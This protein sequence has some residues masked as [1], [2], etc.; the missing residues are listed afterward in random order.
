[1]SHYKENNESV[2]NYKP[3]RRVEQSRVPFFTDIPQ[4]HEHRSNP[5]G[6]LVGILD[7]TPFRVRQCLPIPPCFY[8]RVRQVRHGFH[9]RSSQE[10]F[11]TLTQLRHPW[12]FQLFRSF[13]LYTLFRWFLVLQAICVLGISSTVFKPI[14]VVQFM[15]TRRTFR[16]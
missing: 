14:P 9:F 1:M 4:F 15:L 2:Y 7:V 8:K 3:T 5:S 13:E 6:T 16:F 11:N 10:G 12:L